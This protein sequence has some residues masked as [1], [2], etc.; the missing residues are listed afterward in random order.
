MNSDHG[1]A[2]ARQ[3]AVLPSP[4]FNETVRWRH[5]VV[6]FLKVLP[7]KSPGACG[8][9]RVSHGHC[10][11]REGSRATAVLNPPAPQPPSTCPSSRHAGASFGIC[12]ALSQTWGLW[13]SPPQGLRKAEH[14]ADP[15]LPHLTSSA[16]AG[17]GGSSFSWK[18]AF[19]S[20][21]RP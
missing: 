10:S 7:K 11:P 14:A 5:D 4:L 3:G 18:Q 6:A 20:R 13:R 2:P 17:H 16:R 21:R 19:L 8:S 9:C 12:P 15:L 1:T